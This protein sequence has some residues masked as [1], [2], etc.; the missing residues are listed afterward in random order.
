MIF[1]YFYHIPKTGGTTLHNNIINICK[2]KYKYKFYNFNYPPNV[3]P[4]DVKFIDY[5]KVF[6][7]YNKK[8]YNIVYIHHHLGYQGLLQSKEELINQK[9]KLK[10]EGHTLFILTVIR[11]TISYNTSFINF[12]H[13]WNFKVTKTEYLNNDIFNNIQTNFLFYN[14]PTHY[15]N[16]KK[17]IIKEDLYLL[18]DLIDYIIN[19]ED[20]DKFII[21]LYKEFNINQ[22]PTYFGKK[23]NIGNNKITFDDSQ[24]IILSKNW[25]DNNLIKIL[26]PID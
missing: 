17:Q 19:L 5:N 7:N 24:K 10:L 2:K 15:N 8:N 14:L 20:L 13:K 22:D 4:K 12:L 3:L 6:S 18:S 25:L 23:F 1:I 11:D 16:N 9:N 26:T 21:F